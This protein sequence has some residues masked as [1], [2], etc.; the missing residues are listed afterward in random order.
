MRVMPGSL[1]SWWRKRR[2]GEG[3]VRVVMVR[4]ELC[5][6]GGGAKMKGEGLAPTLRGH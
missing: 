6:L 2:E 5:S 1:G 4:C 3:R